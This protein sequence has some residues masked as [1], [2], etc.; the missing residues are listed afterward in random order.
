VGYDALTNLI[1]TGDTD[2]VRGTYIDLQRLKELVEEGKSEA[3]IMTEL[4]IR[5][6]GALQQALLEVMRQTTSGFNIPGEADAQ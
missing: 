4:D 6:S 1:N 2:M 5:E 3:E